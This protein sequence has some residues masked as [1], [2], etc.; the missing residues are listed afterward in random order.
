MINEITNNMR[1]LFLLSFIILQLIA[2]ENSTNKPNDIIAKVDTFTIPK[3]A[4]P[5]VYNGYVLVQGNVDSIQGSFLIDLGSDWLCL[6]SIFHYSNRSKNYD[7]HR[8]SITGIGNSFQNIVEI[9]DSISLSVGNKRY[10]TADVSVIN[11]KPIGGDL[12]DGLIGT[13]FFIKSVLEINYAKEYIN[14]FSN[15]DSVDISDYKM[16]SMKY[17]GSYFCIP[18]EVKINDSITIKGDFILDTGMPMSTLSSSVIENNN[19]KNNIEHKVS[20]YTKYGGIGG[21]SSGYIFYANSLKI[22]DFCFGNPIMSFSTDKSGLLANEKYTGILGNNILERFDIIFDFKNSNLYLKPNENYK[23]P[24]TLDKLGFFY[25]DRFK[26]MGGWIVTGLIKNSAAE[27]QGLKIDDKI[28]LVNDIPVVNISYKDQINNFP[29][30]DK[31]KLCIKRD[32]LIKNL[33]YKL[34]PLL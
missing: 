13:D 18:L 26:T 4:I 27:R 16:F 8:C 11:M 19:F 5:I 2:C 9:K 23:S 34:S 7:Y 12:I 29:K 22:S 33:E 6:D 20:Y 30:L 17:I 28:I 32:G 15:I 14:I 1:K 31:V 10:R 25:V 21:E 24:F 3:N